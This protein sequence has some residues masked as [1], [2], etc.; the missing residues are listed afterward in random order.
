MGV[1]GFWGSGLR[2]FAFGVLSFGLAGLGCWVLVWTFWFPTL[3]PKACFGVSF[4]QAR[5]PR[6]SVNSMP[7]PKPYTPR[8][9]ACLG[10]KTLVCSRVWGLGFRAWGLGF[11]V[12]CVCVCFCCGW[13]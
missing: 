11:S 6:G 4:C 5:G 13:L 9:G 10:L 12:C 1:L 8:V 7:Q 2:G 3:N